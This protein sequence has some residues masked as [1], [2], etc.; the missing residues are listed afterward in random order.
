M[1]NLLDTLLQGTL[2]GGR[3]ALMAIGLSLAFGVMRLV[4]VAHGDFIVLAAYLALVTVNALGLHP[5]SAL[6]IVVPAMAMLGYAVQRGLL[7]RAIGRDI[8]PALLITFGLSVIIQNSLLEVFSADSRRLQAGNLSSTGVSFADGISMGWFPLMTLATAALT[9][10]GLE[11]FFRRS[12]LGRAFRAVSDDPEIVQLMGYDP[13][14]VHALAMAV[15][16]ATVGIAG[17][18]FGIGTIFD[19]ALGPPQ[20]LFAFEAVIIG[21]M[22]SLWGTLAGSMVLGIAQAIGF[23]IDPGWG[24]LFGHAAFLIILAVRPQ[25]LFPRTRD[26]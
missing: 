12:R 2:L 20:L 3:Y 13:R 9:I 10:G 8:M 18:F 19:P 11:Q 15:A 7:N 22:G 5:L 26:A 21:G 6:L 1:A 17:T 24:I 4:N 16:F 23:R 25:G 14:H